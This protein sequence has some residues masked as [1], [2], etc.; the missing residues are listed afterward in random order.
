[1]ALTKFPNRLRGA[2]QRPRI[3]AAGSSGAGGVRCRCFHA[4]AARAEPRSHVGVQRVRQNRRS[5]IKLAPHRLP[6][7]RCPSGSAA[8][9]PAGIRG[10]HKT[11]DNA[12]VLKMSSAAS[13]SRAAPIRTAGRAGP[14]V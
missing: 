5:S 12:K 8:E 10:R 1:V 9:W 4:G 6:R 13:T 7:C 14:S 11:A 3:D 2:G